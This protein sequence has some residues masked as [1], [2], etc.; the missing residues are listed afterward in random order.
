M[1]EQ[2][3]DIIELDPPEEMPQVCGEGCDDWQRCPESEKYGYC[4]HIHG[5][6][7]RGEECWY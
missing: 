1:I 5:F 2:Y 7:E 6:T 4:E 3:K